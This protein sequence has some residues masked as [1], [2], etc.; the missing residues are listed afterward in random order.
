MKAQL[1]NV[2]TQPNALDAETISPLQRYVQVSGIQH[3]ASS[4][5]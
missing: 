5:R 4:V 2:N 3:R 1:S